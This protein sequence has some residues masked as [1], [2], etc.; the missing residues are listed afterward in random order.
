MVS[1]GRCL[2]APISHTLITNPFKTRTIKQLLE[3]GA[4][5][6]ARTGPTH[7]PPLAWVLYGNPAFGAVNGVSTDS[8]IGPL[9][10]K[11]LVAGGADVNQLAIDQI[12]FTPLQLACF[13]GACGE[14]VQALL[15]AGADMLA[16]CLCIGWTTP[17]VVAAC[18]GGNTSALRVLIDQ[19]QS[20]GLNGV[21]GQ[22][23]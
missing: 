14:V 22:E 11:T 5:P 17:L 8:T 23:R 16:P 4:D 10:V 18:H 20:G 7:V 1:P 2:I 9:L 19:P 12:G 21:G 3:A 15:D 13:E 6:Q